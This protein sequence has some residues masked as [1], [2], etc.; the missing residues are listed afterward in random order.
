M[1]R[2]R[3]VAVVTTEVWANV[4]CTSSIWVNNNVC[5]CASER[6]EAAASWLEV[7][8]NHQLVLVNLFPE[9]LLLTFGCIEAGW[10]AHGIEGVS[11]ACNQC[12]GPV[13]PFNGLLLTGRNLSRH[14]CSSALHMHAHVYM[15]PHKT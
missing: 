8:A 7:E 4:L 3:A 13:C 2:C 10:L 5:L 6:S 12:T 11:W 9:Q 15:H 14:I 1:V